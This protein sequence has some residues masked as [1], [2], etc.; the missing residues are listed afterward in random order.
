MHQATGCRILAIMGS[1]E[2]SPTM[3]TVH[4][5]LVAR[6]ET[7]HHAAVLLETPYRFQENADDISARA[8][9]YFSRSVGLEVT[10]QPGT[11]PPGPGDDGAAGVLRAADW[12]FACR[13]ARPTH[14]PNGGIARWPG[15]CGTGCKPAGE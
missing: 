3:V 4:R 10:A 2:T 1:G 8:Q 12:V 15:R 5:A 11:R 7:D 13:A 9:A 14:S 6:L